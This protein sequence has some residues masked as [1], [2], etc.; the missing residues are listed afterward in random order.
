MYS[1]DLAG[2][3]LDRLLPATFSTGFGLDSPCTGP[4]SFLNIK[5]NKS[6]SAETEILLAG[7]KPETRN[8]AAAWF[9]VMA[10]ED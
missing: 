6:I 10:E 9:S 2:L 1:V 3:R 5:L 4:Y 7:S 8:T